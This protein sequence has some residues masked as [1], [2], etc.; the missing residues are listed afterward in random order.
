[1]EKRVDKMAPD[2]ML[3]VYSLFKQAE[4]GDVPDEELMQH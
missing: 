3:A 1:M 2:A 4:H